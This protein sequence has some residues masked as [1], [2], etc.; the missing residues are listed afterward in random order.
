MFINKQLADEI[1]HEIKNIIPFYFNIMD[2]TGLILT[3]TDPKRI[4]TTHE[5]TRLMVE[6]NLNEL[7]IERENQ[8]VGCT[9][10]VLLSIRFAT[11]IIGFIGIK[12]VP[13]KI[14]SY[15]YIIQKMMELLVYEKFEIYRQETDENAKSVLINSLI[16]G[17]AE[18][19][20]F[21]VQEE[22]SKNGLSGK[23]N[24]TVGILKYP[25]ASILESNTDII[26]ARQ[27]IVKRHI[28]NQLS[29]RNILAF[30]NNEQCIM[31]SNLSPER[32]YSILEILC[33]HVEEQYK[34]VLLGTVSNKYIK[35]TAIPKAYNE[36]N[37]MID[38]LVSASQK[39]IFYYDPQNLD[40]IIRQISITHKENLYSKVFQDCTEEEIYEFALF[41]K[42][43]ADCNGSLKLLSEKYYLHKNTIQY[44]IKKIHKK[45]CLD[46]R[47]MK[48]LFILYIAVSN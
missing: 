40:F 47:I 16:S 32:L 19:S 11:K 46:M 38:F 14:L 8:Y 18:Y 24:F 29:D 10:G 17:Q 7:I 43:Y 13:N 30:N 5:G 35:Y 41:V 20:F 22:L 48:D 44:K 1:A 2:D 15:G 23:D 12:G 28:L 26:E 37:T 34:I 25:S 21:E 39:G 42:A 27:K 36:A 3:C 6:Q 33:R 45:T 31:V 9:M 4:G